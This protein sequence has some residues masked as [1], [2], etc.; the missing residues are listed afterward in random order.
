MGLMPFQGWRLWF[1]R[2]V[3]IAVFGIFISRMYYL[4]FVEG[5]S[6]RDDAEENRIQILPIASSRGSILDRNG[7]VLARNVP[8]FNVTI[9]PAFLPDDPEEVLRIYNRLAGLINVPATNEVVIAS[10]VNQRSLEDLVDEGERIA[11]FRPVTV[12]TDIPQAIMLQL[13]EEKLTLP[14][15]NIE[16][17]SVREYPTGELTSQIIGY[18]GPIGE[19]EAED[20]REQGYD[21]SFDRIGYAGIERFFETELA[22]QRGS[23]T[24][25][26]DVAGEKLALLDRQDPLAG[27]TIQLTLDTELQRAAQ[28]ALIERI[29]ILNAQEQKLRSQSGVVIAMDPRTGEIL[30]LVSWPTYDNSR[31]ARSID[32]DYYFDLADDQLLPLVNHATGSLYPP[33][34]VWKLVS[35]VAV[36][37]EGV[38][39][40]DSYLFDGGR[41]QLPNAFA[42]NDVAQSQTFVCW[43]RNGHGRVN[44]KDA[45]AIS[46]DVYFYQVGGGNPDVSSAV[47]RPGGL[48]IDDLY[49]WATAFGVGSELGIEL[50][51][52]V[53]GRMPDRDWK[54]RLYGESWSTG[55]TYNAAFG[56][57][58]LTVTPL[59]QLSYT[60]AIANGGTL[61][62]P[63]IIKQF[64][65]AQ[66]NVVREFGPRVA[67]TIVLPQNGDVVLLLQ[68]DLL[69]QKANSLVCRCEPDSDHYDPARCNPDSYTAQVD[70]DPNREDNIRNIITYRV[71]VPYNYT[72]NGR[73]CD[74]LVYNSNVARD[75]VPPFASSEVVQLVEEG[76]REVVTRGTASTGV[77]PVDPLP[78]VNEAGK[79]GTAEYCDDIARP[80]GLCI[81]GRWPS[82]AWYVGYA[83]YE[84]P[85]IV[86]VAFVYNAG[87]GSQV[88]LPVVRRVLDFYFRRQ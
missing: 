53:A 17:R 62:Q 11:P 44:L 7:Q 30:A 71:N 54:R 59:Q 4:Q 56:Q 8:A 49:R 85:E 34:S 72:F 5:I 1:F 52:E 83:P 32:V 22:G 13:E 80:L 73:V 66:G 88:A 15:V 39:S 16:V 67:R 18:I 86:V 48:G 57:G 61:Y 29:N 75:Y 74:P 26:V 35:A 77:T 38:I 42:P 79:T 87:E 40:P 41:L 68:E 58:Y 65:D 43:D 21:P 70:I 64:L 19:D 24:Y 82:H 36:A 6:F 14:G 31:F 55:D 50:P 37:E 47:L 20:L 12:A 9:T 27:L 3:I 76:M 81:P 23:E 78:Y 28:E 10:G 2:G 45:I 84:A 25:E 60:A 69:I 46:C 51:L 63:T 33:G